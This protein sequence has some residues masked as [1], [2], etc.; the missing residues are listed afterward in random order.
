M[1][2]E[3]DDQAE[4]AELIQ[5]TTSAFAEYES[6]SELERK[7]RAEAEK[8]LQLADVEASKAQEA[9]SRVEEKAENLS[10]KIQLRRAKEVPSVIEEPVESGPPIV[11]GKS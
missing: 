8:W 6:S 7:Y 5:E 10:D 11:K 1:A 4:V 9:W 2:A 3:T